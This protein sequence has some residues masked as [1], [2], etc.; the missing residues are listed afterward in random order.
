MKKLI[1]VIF[2]FWFLYHIPNQLIAENKVP[3]N[4]LSVNQLI[5]K[6]GGSQAEIMKKIML[7]ESGGSDTALGDHGL[8]LG[9][10]QYHKPTWDRFSK[11]YGQEMDYHSGLDQIKVTGFIFQQYPQYRNSWTCFKK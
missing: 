11:L 10:F 6:Y 9:K 7:C 4:L 3:E 8:A 2:V 1:F 5:D